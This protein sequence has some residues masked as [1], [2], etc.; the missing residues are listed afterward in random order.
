MKTKQ[1]KIFS[2]SFRNHR[3]NQTQGNESIFQKQTSHFPKIYVYIYIYICF[4]F[5]FS[6]ALDFLPF[7]QITITLTR[8]LFIF[9]SYIAI[10]IPKTS[11]F[12]S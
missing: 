9:S 8:I 6:P 7:T 1:Y 3:I 5:L 2:N 4:V 10:T 12:L 11:L